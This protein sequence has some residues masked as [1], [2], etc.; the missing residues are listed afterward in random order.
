M[1]IKKH[2]DISPCPFCGSMPEYVETY[3][4]NHYVQCGHRACD[5]FVETRLCD[6]REDAIAVWNRRG[7]G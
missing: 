3:E 1:T 5:V 6:T 7:G 4:G 2:Y